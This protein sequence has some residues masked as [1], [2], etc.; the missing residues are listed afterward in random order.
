MLSLFKPD[1]HALI[2]VKEPNSCI[3]S[4]NKLCFSFF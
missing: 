4:T 3:Q 1:N 2:Y